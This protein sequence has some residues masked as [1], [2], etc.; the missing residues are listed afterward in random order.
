VT[1][2]KTYEI[3]LSPAL[4]KKLFEFVKSTAITQEDFHWITQN[5]IEL[6]YCDDTLTMDEYE[7]AI[8]KP[9][10]M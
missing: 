7:L 6:S 8:K 1:K 4:L 10:T 5:L 2:Y 9:V 3:E